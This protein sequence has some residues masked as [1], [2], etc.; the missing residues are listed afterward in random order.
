MVLLLVV[1][2]TFY[3]ILPLWGAWRVR[4]RWDKFREAATEA[5]GSPEIDFSLVQSAG[6]LPS[7]AFRLT[8]TLEAFE[9]SDRLWIGNDRVSVAVSLRGAPVYFVDEQTDPFGPG[10]EPPRRAEASSLGTLPEGTQFLV[11]GNLARDARGQV[12]FASQPDRKLLVLAFEG[13]PGTVLTRAVFAGR[14]TL[15]HWNSWTPVSVGMG[16]LL[17]FLLAWRGLR[18]AGDP[19][20]GLWALAVALL[21]STF[22]LPPGILFFYAFARI[23]TRARNLR[24]QLALVRLHGPGNGPGALELRRRARQLELV[25]QVSL[26]VALGSNVV[27]L[28]EIL[29]FWVL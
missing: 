6:D 11:W 5:L 7:Q 18:P 19:V 1:G 23:W 12:H 25:A 24:A 22:F 16:V 21:P 9:G 29:R 8:G 4:R 26:T 17:A 13:N 20:T 28:A 15:E 2:L 27:L 14:A 10:V 3:A